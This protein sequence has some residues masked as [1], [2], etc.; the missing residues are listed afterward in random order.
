MLL[1]IGGTLL[2]TPGF[3]RNKWNVVEPEKY[4]YW[5]TTVDRAVVARL[6]KT[7]QDGLL[8]SGGLLGLGDVKKWNFLNKTNNRQYIVYEQNGRK[9]K[10]YYPYRSCSGFQGAVFGMFD[11]LTKFPNNTNL[12]VFRG[13]V[14]VGSAITLALIAVGL[15]IE[16]GLLGAAL[17]LVF[18]VFSEWLTLPAG[19]IFW[20][21]WSIYLPFVGSMLLMAHASRKQVYRAARIHWVLYAAC[22]VKIL[23]SG[24]EA[25]TTVL[26][27]ITVPFVYF[28]VLEK[29]GWRVFLERMVK[30]G[31]A[32][33]AAVLTGLLI[34]S[35]QIAL[36]DGSFSASLTWILKAF[37]RRAIGNPANYTG[38][39]AESMSASV[40]FVIW[41]YLAIRSIT[42][43]IQQWTWPVAYWQLIA[44]FAFF[45]VLFLL[46]QKTG[47]DQAA[48]N[49]GRALIVATWYSILAPLSWFIVFK[50][51]SYI[52]TSIYPMVWQMPFALLGTVL[53]GF[54]IRNLFFRAKSP[55]GAD[56]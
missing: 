28:A 18:V 50:P 40:L 49:K 56:S 17:M 42:I 20:N 19:S 53:C 27:M 48:S 2:L 54:V 39:Y 25:I 29:W 45:T 6:V 13:A 30:L 15:A 46:R 12:K 24:F 38:L 32:L 22:L 1:F 21:L 55:G 41:K 31:L 51:N 8:S 35:L 26:V 33:A 14:A 43:N 3:Y 5:Q 47:T 11:R 9:F 23:F 4:E 44:L 37:D 36:A 52:H 10:S 34:L 16:F 7:R